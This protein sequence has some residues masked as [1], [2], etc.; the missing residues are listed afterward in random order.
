MIPEPSRQRKRPWDQVSWWYSLLL[1]VPLIGF[2]ATFLWGADGDKDA[3]SGVVRDALTGDPISG[4]IVSTANATAT[5]DGNGSFSVDDLTASSLAVSREDYASTQVALDAPGGDIDIALRP[6]TIRGRVRN[7]KTGDPMSG[8][9]VTLTGPDGQVQTVTTNDDGEYVI[10]NV[11]ESGTIAVVFENVTVASRD[12]GS[13]PELDFDIRP[14]VLTGTVTD[15][16]GQPIA[17]AEVTIGEARAETANDG[18]YRIPAVPEDGTITVRKAG[19]VDASG[20]LPDSLVFDAELEAFLVRAIYAS[21]DTAADNGLWSNMVD[22]ANDTAVNAIVVDLKDSTG[23]VLYDSQ[24]PLVEEVGAETVRFDVEERLQE[25]DNEEIYAIARIVVFEDPLLAEKRPELAI[26]DATS[27]GRWTTWDGRAW[28]NPHRREVWEYN[29]AIA[30]EA[31][32][33]GFD[34]VQFDYVRFPLDGLLENAFYGDEYTN[35]SRADAING[36]LQQAKTAITP[37]GAYLA[38]DVSGQAMWDEGDAGI[39]QNLGAIAPLVDV[40]SPMIYPSHFYPG[41]LGLDIPNNYPYEVVLWSLRNG[42]ERVPESAY[43]IR[44][45]LQD[46]SYGEG[47]EYG[48]AEVAEQ[49][50]A[51]EEVGGNGWMLW[52]PDSTYNTGG[53]PSE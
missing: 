10:D 6:T 3:V 41:E 34:E 13:S 42:A 47:I 32:R 37:T 30:S 43:K 50:R 4:A 12:L 26:T 29:I 51:A 21:G 38:V 17:G 31:A 8:V 2:A 28:V 52:N 44:P 45:W 15:S 5:T 18:T 40:V 16:R 35:E 11:P 19:F 36:F 22:I 27:G 1:V 23:Q 25:L 20:E 48:D 7:D 24:V 33:L 49:I 53:I 39:G 9:I 46:F 14:D